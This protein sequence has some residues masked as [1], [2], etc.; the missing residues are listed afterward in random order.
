MQV[1]LYKAAADV[2]EL[3]DQIDPETGE[4]PEGLEQA[5]A[6]VATKAQ[7]V[8]AF[9]LENEAQADMVEAHAKELLER[10]K[11]ARKR[12]KW[13]KDYLASH[14]SACGITEIK[15]NDGTFKAKLD[16]GRDKSVEIVQPDL[17]PADYMREIPAK[18][19]PDKTLIKK[20]IDDGFDV[21]GAR[22]ICKDRLTI[23]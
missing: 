14:M 8:A 22:V 17:V 16:I 23:K 2:R 19:E 15:S 5:R 12:S 13:L 7:S 11:A 9:I 4:L 1:S 3:L 18:Y 10:C 21:A 20:A 6:I